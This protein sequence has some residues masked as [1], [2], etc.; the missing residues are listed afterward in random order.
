MFLWPISSGFV[1]VCDMYQL[2][3]WPSCFQQLFDLKAGTLFE[4]SSWV[5]VHMYICL[6][7]YE[8]LYCTSKPMEL[9]ESP[10]VPDA[11]QPSGVWVCNFGQ[12]STLTKPVPILLLL[13][14]LL[15][16]SSPS[17]SIDKTPMLSSSDSGSKHNQKSSFCSSCFPP[18]SLTWVLLERSLF[19]LGANWSYL[20]QELCMRRCGFVDS[21]RSTWYWPYY[22]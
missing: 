22:S 1:G 9:C 7:L 20:L 15:Y 14:C 3:T 11:L 8:F 6:C 5:C 2:S 18:L 21:T 12:H 13:V 10:Q 17:Q 16:I 19:A 4:L